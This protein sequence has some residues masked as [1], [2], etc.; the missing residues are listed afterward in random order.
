MND[1][2]LDLER[3][4]HELFDPYL[5]E[6]P[7]PWRTRARGRTPA[8]M[9]GGLGGALLAKLATGAVLAALAAGAGIEAANTH[10]LSPVDWG[11]AVSRQVQGA[12]PGK[13]STPAAHSTSTPTSSRRTPGAT[14]APTPAATPAVSPP[15]VSPLPL[16]SVSPIAVPSVSPPPLPSIP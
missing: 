12:Q 13:A 4:L 3:G 2:E 15:A 6:R 16:P 7:E 5:A 10:S 1:F 8:R 9:A 14:L 11:R